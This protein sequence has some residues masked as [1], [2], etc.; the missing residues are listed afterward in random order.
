MSKTPSGSLT[1]YCDPVTMLAFVD[2]RLVAELCSDDNTLIPKGDLVIDPADPTLTN[3]NPNLAAALLAAS[4]ELEA[5][6]LVG[7][8]YAAADLKALTGASADYLRMIVAYLALGRLRQRRGIFDDAEHPQ[9]KEARAIVEQLKEGGS[10]FAFVEVSEAGVPHV[11]F[12]NLS[13]YMKM[14]L[15]SW[16]ARRWLGSRANQYPR[17]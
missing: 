4:G 14:D 15:A 7:G 3:P 2:W 16:Q 10:I 5:A 12:Y 1:S 6:C 9:V 17:F 11:D 13:D 8:R